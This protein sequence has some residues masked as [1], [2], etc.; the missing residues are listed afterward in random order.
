[1]RGDEAKQTG[2][3]IATDMPARAPVLALN[4]AS[5]RLVDTD[6]DTDI[7]VLHAMHARH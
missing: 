6:V 4:S 7:G 2:R 3:K 5:F 1:M